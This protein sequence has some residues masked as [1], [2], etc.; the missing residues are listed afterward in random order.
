MMLFWL[1]IVVL[2]VWLGVRFARPHSAR[3]DGNSTARRILADRY[4]RGELDTEEYT[5]RLENLR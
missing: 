3:E 5:H 4:A 1:G 2:V